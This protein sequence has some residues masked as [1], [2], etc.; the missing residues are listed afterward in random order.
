MI[1]NVWTQ[2]SGY[3]LGSF[4]QGITL[5]PPI[6]IAL[7]IENDSGVS[8]KV[9]SGSLPSGLA[10][11]GNHIT[12]TPFLVSNNP[13]FTFCI[14]AS[15]GADFADRTFTMNVYTT[16]RPEFITDAGELPIG[17]GGQLYV[18]DSTYVDYQLE[19]YDYNT[20]TGH[21]L[22]YYIA[23]GDGSLPPGLS[24]SENGLIQGFIEPRL[25]ISKSDGTGTFD[26]S[27]F[28]KVA[29]DFGRTPTD[30]YDSY[31]YD[32]VFYDFNTPTLQPK[33]LSANYQF[34]VTLSD[35]VNLTQRVFRIF[36]VGTD[37]FHADST[38]L[39]GLA[40]DFNAD[41]SF[42][43]TPV[44]ITNSVL[45]AFRAN[46]YITIPMALYDPSNVEFDI[47]DATKLPPGLRFDANTGDLY[48]VVPYQPSV[49]KSYSFTITATRLLGN[50]S[51]TTS[52]IFTIIILGTI[53]SEIVWN[54]PS[55]LGSIP[56]NYISTLAVSAN[57]NIADDVIVFELTSGSLPV[58]L[59]LNVDGEIIGTPNQFYDRVTGQ[60]GLTTFDVK[61]N[62]DRRI[63]TPTTFDHGTTTF[64]R[65]Y[66]FGITAKNQYG[67]S[68]VTR[69]F[70]VT[71]TEP[72]TTTYSN[73]TTKPMLVPSQRLLWHDFIN[74]TSIFTPAKIY[75]PNDKNFGLQSNLTMLVYAGIQTEVAA[76]YVGAMGLNHK[77]KRFQFG[78]VKKAIA[79][80]PVTHNAVYEVIYIQMADPLE[81][82]GLHLPTMVKSTVG[83]KDTVTVDENISID[84]TGYLISSPNS[85]EYFPNS[86]S[87]WRERL[88]K[89]GLNERNYLPLWMRSVGS[90]Q[91]E[92]LGYT[93]A[94]PLCFCKPGTADTIMI[95][96]KLSGFDFKAIDYTVDRYTINA[97]LDSQG[98]VV[99]GD[100][101][102]VFKN[103]RITV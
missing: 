30:G 14:R 97:V 38:T 67:Y 70:T 56:A 26:A 45:G 98:R 60:L 9:I 90:G 77:K 43:R 3:S 15:K 51:V 40:G 31:L 100:K 50:D 84:S 49:T 89:V 41:A 47:V 93:L 13:K 24:L 37:E 88:K 103:D 16:A 28:D 27:L 12:G 92:E 7:P 87:N 75:R 39:S 61:W 22:T 29:F 94:I 83:N 82:N 78:S 18:L 33:S 36:V 58:G 80:D 81:P 53:N 95:A 8:Y 96:I 62:K 91:K 54:T 55:N 42:V 64:E 17:L 46:N 4:Q 34:K 65:K 57:S 11:R 86:I 20:T 69:T 25:I 35:G 5:N 10:I 48:G 21:S 85:N 19:A 68:A 32:N 79:N 71:I 23:D 101:Y 66:T 99:Y 74:N 59:A 44:W 1:L 63:S 73:I 76:A 52:K 6:G 102:L 2:P 72:N